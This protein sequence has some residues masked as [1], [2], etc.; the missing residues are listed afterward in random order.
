MQL[1]PYD[2]NASSMSISNKQIKEILDQSQLRQLP[3]M[4]RGIAALF[5]GYA[6]FQFYLLQEPGYPIMTGYALGCTVILVGLSFTY[7]TLFSSY[8]QRVNWL[9]GIVA[10][11]V[12]S[13]TLLRLWVT[14]QPKQSANLILFMVAA[15]VVFVSSRWFYGLLAAALLGWLGWVAGIQWFAS[16]SYTTDPDAVYWGLVLIASA[17]TA[18]ILHHTRGDV[19][20]RTALD[21]IRERDQKEKI[22]HQKMQLQTAASVGKQITS[23]LDR[24]ELLDKITSQI[25]KQYHIRYVGIYLPAEQNLLPSQLTSVAHAGQRIYTQQTPDEADWSQ[26]LNMVYR[27]GMISCLD[28]SRPVQGKGE[29]TTL[30]VPLKM[31]KTPLGVLV[32]QSR[33][34]ASLRASDQQT[35]HLLADQVSAALENARLYAQIVKIN[36]SLEATVA[37]RT[38]ELQEAYAR[39]ERL[40]KTKSDFITI[41]SHELKTPLTLITSYSQMF[42]V[43]EALVDNATYKKW[44]DRING[45]VSRLNEIVDRMNDVALIDSQSLEL[46]IAP[47]NLHFLLAGV[48]GRL[49]DDLQARQITLQLEAGLK[50]LPDIEGDIEALEKVFWQ[51]FTNGMKYTPDG[52]TIRVNGR[53]HTQLDGKTAVEL[54]VTDSGI[55]FAPEDKELLFDKFYQ[56]GEV[57][58]HSSG[59]TSFKAG[60]AGIGLAIAKGIVE[61]HDGTIWAESSGYSEETLPGS[62]F[63]VLL[64]VTGTLV[65]D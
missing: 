24:E 38:R 58:L 20:T 65:T 18:A 11:L 4:T 51:L 29:Q 55:G 61:A 27:N 31:G 25:Q 50:Q 16:P 5:F 40:D 43:D 28:E 54:T 15:G 52:G 63:H 57:D 22:E 47:V 19:F 42:A 21:Q 56:T 48:K 44:I 26:Q 62:Q 33:S 23:I 34:K 17:L 12:L 39:L 32:L 7:Q 46:Y 14:G 10:A 8:E 13:S 64:P 6:V 59:T 35:F 30:F 1:R 2:H 41:A 36:R 3:L 60:G 37:D 49:R 45:G 9:L 53:L